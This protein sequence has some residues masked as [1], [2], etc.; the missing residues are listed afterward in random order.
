LRWLD[1]EHDDSCALDYVAIY[2]L[3]V[4]NTP[5]SQLP[6]HDD[7]DL[8]DPKWC[9]TQIKQM[10]VAS[11]LAKQTAP[12]PDDSNIYTLAAAD[13]TFCGHCAN[14]PAPGEKP[15]TSS[16]A[17]FIDAATSHQHSAT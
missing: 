11:E 4:K 9:W 2:A 15:H 16:L 6:A 13:T 5:A 7:G 8:N 10:E 14:G 17:E 12:P 3:V 1:D